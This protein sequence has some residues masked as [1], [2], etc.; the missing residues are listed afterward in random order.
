MIQQCNPLLGIHPEKTET[1]ISKDIC[2]LMFIAALFTIA[3]IWKQPWCLSRE[4]WIKMCYVYNGILLSHQKV[5]NRAICDNMAGPRGYYVQW[6]KPEKDKHR[7]F[8]CTWIL[9]NK[10]TKQNSDTEKRL[11]AA[12]GERNGGWVK[13]VMGIRRY[14]PP[15]TRQGDV[16]YSMMT[17]VTVV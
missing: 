13:W 5:W 3:K 17:L 6:N 14:K 8:P 15:V 7:Y 4:E 11:A 12:R 16:M 9:K 10:H 1:L 2:T